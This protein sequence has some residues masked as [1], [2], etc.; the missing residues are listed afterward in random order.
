MTFATKSD[1]KALYERLKYQLGRQTEYA[2]FRGNWFVLAGTQ[3]L[4]GVQT[5]FYM[6]AASQDGTVRGFYVFYSPAISNQIKG[7]IV[8]MS[9]DFEPFPEAN[10]KTASVAQSPALQNLPIEPS[11]AARPKPKITIVPTRPVQAR[12]GRASIPPI[13]IPMKMQGG[14]YAVPVQINGAIKLDF[15]V[16]SGASDVNIPFD[17]FSTLIRSGTIDKGDIIGSATYSIAD[18]STL[19]G[20]QFRIHSLKIGNTFVRNVVGS[21]GPAKGSLLLGQSFLRKFK[22]WS[23]DN[24]NHALLLQ[25]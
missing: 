23:I 11:D 1:L 10:T 25:K 15:V 2:P 8:V 5:D 13:S 9:S 16:D 18:G 17:V 4:E 3:Q 22:S 7:L 20:I 21:V 24:T 14:T 6:R 12:I 19:R